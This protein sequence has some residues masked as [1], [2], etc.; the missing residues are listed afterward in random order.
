MGRS[1]KAPTP[2]MITDTRGTIEYVNPKFTEL[3]GYSAA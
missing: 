2:A 3:T 1:R